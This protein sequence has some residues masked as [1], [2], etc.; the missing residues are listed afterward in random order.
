MKI[1]LNSRV[2]LFPTEE[3]IIEIKKILRKDFETYNFGNKTLEE[4]YSQFINENGEL[5]YYFWNIINMFGDLFYNGSNRIWKN[6]FV[7]INDNDEL[8]KNSWKDRCLAAE[9]YIDEC[10]CDPDIYPEQYEA[11]LNWLNLKK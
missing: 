10:P 7:E 2:K 3:G 5:E 4:Y 8:L 1:N 9:K 11:Y 6:S